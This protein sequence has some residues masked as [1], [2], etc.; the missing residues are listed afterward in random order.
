MGL[1]GWFVGPVVITITPDGINHTY[2]KF[3]ADDPWQEY[4][5][6]ITV[7]VDG[8]YELYVNASDADGEYHI[9]GP[10]PFR[11][12]QTPPYINVTVVDHW[13][14][15]VNCSDNMSGVAF[16]EFYV[17]DVLVG[18][19]TQG[20][21]YTF[22]YSG[23]GKVAKIAVYDIAGNVAWS[24]K[25]NDAVLITNQYVFSFSGQIPITQRLLE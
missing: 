24:P 9:Y 17:D 16:V 13:T 8:R 11:I 23:K 15:I 22:T 1:N 12:D 2:Y 19:D 21:I 4:T 3:H 7:S 10:Y 20:P 6:P 18:N 5:A 14:F 25:I